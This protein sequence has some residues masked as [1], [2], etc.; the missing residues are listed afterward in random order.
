MN[1][2]ARVL[3]VSATLDIGGTETHLLQILP[4]LVRHG[5]EIQLFVLKAG[6]SLTNE[7]ESHGIEII[8]PTDQR[9]GILGLLYSAAR[10]FRLLKTRPF[11]VVHFFLPAPYVVGAPIALVSSRAKLVMS[12]RSLNTY[13]SRYPG[14]RLIERILHPRMDLVCGN[15]QAVVDQ[16]L[17]EGIPRSKLLLI[18]NGVDVKQTAVSAEKH[19]DDAL[20]NFPEGT[21]VFVCV[22]NLFRYKGH[23]NVLEAFHLAKPHLPA[24]WRLICV[25]R[26]AGEGSALEAQSVALGLSQHVIWLGELPSVTS[27]LNVANVAVQCSLEEG[28]SNAILEA[29]AAG[30]PI[31]ATRVGGNPDAVQHGVNGILLDPG[32]SR[33]LAKALIEI[34]RS[35]S[36]MQQMGDASLELVLERFSIE[37]CVA[38]YWEMYSRLLAVNS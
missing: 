34:S 19:P 7:F 25:G 23:A 22:A 24:S 35:P 11:D 18:H 5:L 9:S 31:I 26:D 10:L 21:V 8:S 30:L 12:R 32:D 20:F 14:I 4:R 3:I 29:M 28:F 13:Q 33:E 1:E 16:L 38:S 37:T 36:L 17:D 27:I 6:G 2:S 15:S